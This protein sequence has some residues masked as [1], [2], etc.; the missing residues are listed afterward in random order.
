MTFAQS[1]S[2]R[3]TKE[4]IYLAGALDAGYYPK[5]QLYPAG[6]LE[7]PRVIYENMQMMWQTIKETRQLTGLR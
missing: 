1:H 6:G 4:S 2:Q 5:S 3:R 7:L